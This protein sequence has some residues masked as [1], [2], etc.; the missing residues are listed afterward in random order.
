MKQTD[1]RDGLKVAVRIGGSE[2]YPLI[3]PA[4][5]E[6]TDS[7][8][9]PHHEV[10]ILDG[11]SKDKEFKL[12]S[13]GVIAVWTK[14]H[15]EYFQAREQKRVTAEREQ[16]AKEFQRQYAN[17]RLEELGSL[18]QIYAGLEESELQTREMSFRGPGGYFTGN[19][20]CLSLSDVET[21]VSLLRKQYEGLA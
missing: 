16:F 8:P 20:L 19:Y 6:K 12:T 2:R 4:I 15:E 21:I 14:E 1:L 7:G 13:R 9:S 17:E 11:P 3:A 18:L 10:R 5:I